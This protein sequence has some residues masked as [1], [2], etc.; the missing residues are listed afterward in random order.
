MRKHDYITG[1][2]SGARR[3]RL[4]VGLDA[5]P[6]FR[7]G[8]ESFASVRVEAMTADCF[9]NT[10]YCRFCYLLRCVCTLRH[11]IFFAFLLLILFMTTAFP[12]C[13][14]VCIFHRSIRAWC[15]FSGG[16]PAIILRCRTK[17]RCEGEQQR[18]YM[19]ACVFFCSSIYLVS[20]GPLLLVRAFFCC[21]HAGTLTPHRDA[22]R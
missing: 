14:G 4:C 15:C 11:A 12:F 18:E 7:R 19:N 1:E 17:S 9:T 3:P 10:L 22:N 13:V 21:P 5:A 8:E 16:A 2:V 6:R 20:Y